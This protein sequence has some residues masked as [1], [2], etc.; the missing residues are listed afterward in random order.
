M[1]ASDAQHRRRYYDELSALL[2]SLQS[3]LVTAPS[4]ETYLNKVAWLAAN[5]LQPAGSCGITT[6]YDGWPVTVAASDERATLADQGQ[7]TED[8]GPCLE[9]LR[10]G[11]VVDVGDQR[12]DERWTSYR[13]HA[14]ELGIRSSLSVP[15]R[16][17]VGES[18]GALNLYSFYGYQV[19]GGYER[20][21]AEAFAREASGALVQTVRRGALDKVTAQIDEALASRA[22][23]E[24]ALGIVMAQERCDADQAFGK[25]RSRSRNDIHRIREVATE[26]IA[27]ATGRAPVVPQPLG[28]RGRV[29]GPDE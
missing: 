28:P 7:Y 24:Q 13:A 25:L 1:A 23:I 22:L 26:T 10:V 29:A 6:Q 16:N 17:L 20:A 18:V 11:E 9:A 21:R 12:A 3:I 8:Q 4:L 19:L 5:I 2:A 27:R 14:V 15:M